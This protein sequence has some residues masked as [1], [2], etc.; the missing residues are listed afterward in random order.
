MISR[1]KSSCSFFSTPSAT[2]FIPDSFA[3]ATVCFI[4]LSPLCVP[5][6]SISD[7]SS[8]MTS[9]RKIYRL[10]KE[11]YPAPKSSMCKEKPSLISSS[12]KDL[13]DELFTA[14]DSV[15]SIGTHEREMPMSFAIL[16]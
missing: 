11:E 2:T 10:A 9:K 13:T 7:L 8:F 12:A 4:R 15:I 1:K 14:I 5:I 3:K 16:A 6:K